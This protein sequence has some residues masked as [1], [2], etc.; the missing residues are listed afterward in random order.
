MTLAEL[1]K[2]YRIKCRAE[3]CERRLAKLHLQRRGVQSPLFDGTPK[4][5]STSSRVEKLALEIVEVESALLDLRC[6]YFEER[7]RLERYI[8]TIPDSRLRLIFTAR[9]VEGLTWEKVA[10]YV[11]GNTTEYGARMLCYRYIRG[12]E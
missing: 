10:R 11:G 2:L 12:Q 8:A 4:N 5:K 3:E 6:R 7:L 1:S 9:F